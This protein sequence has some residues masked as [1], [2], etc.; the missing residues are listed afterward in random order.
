MKKHLFAAAMAVSALPFAAHAQEGDKPAK[1]IEPYVGVLGGMEDFDSESSAA[2]IPP[3]GFRG[4]LVE[5]VV[6]ANVYTGGPLV[7]GVEGN[8]AKGFS[9][10]IDWQYGAAGRVGIRAGDSSMIFG[11]V[12]Y[13]W[14]NF[15]SLG[16][17]SRDYDG[18]TYGAGVEL[19][20]S[21]MGM[22]EGFGKNMKLRMQADTFG[23]FHSFRP[24]IGLV[25][26]F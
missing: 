12:G 4:G 23:N 17:Q 1:T 8:V 15:D 16:P 7:L 9:G 19:S 20:G 14:T 21:D 10:D 3:V 24:M 18:M 2:G 25:A 26:G 22:K 6:G 11:K 5:G 13:R